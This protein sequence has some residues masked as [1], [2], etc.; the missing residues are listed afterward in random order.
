M[1]WQR[2]LFGVLVLLLVLLTAALAAALA[3]LAAARA[4]LRA[5][6]APRARV[7]LHCAATPPPPT[8]RSVRV[9]YVVPF[10]VTQRT[11]VAALLR[12][13]RRWPAC[14]AP[15]ACSARVELL[16][17]ANRPLGDARD[18]AAHARGVAQLQRAVA[19]SGCVAQHLARV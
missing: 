19:S 16:L 6:A 8:V 17:Y 15:R 11:R 13:W 4:D 9:A 7:P 18:A 1:R 14:R 2:W 3:A 12:R 10:A 5:L